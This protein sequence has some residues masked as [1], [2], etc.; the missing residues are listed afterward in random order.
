MTI[1]IYHDLNS[2]EQRKQAATVFYLAFSTKLN[3]L[4]LFPKNEEQAI[5][6]LTL[7]MKPESAVYALDDG[8][9]V[10]VLGL[11]SP[12]G[13]RFLTFSWDTLRQEFGGFGAFWRQIWQWFLHTGD[14]TADALHVRGIAIHE[15]MRGQGLGTCLLAEAEQRARA[16]GC[17]KLAL[18]VVDTNPQARRLYER[19]GF[20]HIRRE[21]TGLLTAGAGFT[22]VDYMEKSV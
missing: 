2:I 6:I 7:S 9:V 13:A 20:Q 12:K 8:H 18:E 21:S 15:S 22:H 10:G 11:D 1:E 5:R 19:L 3:H 17:S 16:L 14:I 4:E